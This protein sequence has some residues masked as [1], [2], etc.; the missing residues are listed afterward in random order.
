MHRWCQFAGKTGV[1][2]CDDLKKLNEGVKR[3]RYVLPTTEKITARLSGATTFSSLDA[4][5]GVWQIPLHPESRKLTTFITPFGRYAF[6]RLPFGITSAL[7][8]SNEK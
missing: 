7:K 3:E 4:A 8:Y 1:C 2:I 5:S 6:K